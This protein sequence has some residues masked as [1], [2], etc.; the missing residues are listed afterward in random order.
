[1][2][3]VRLCAV[4]SM[5]KAACQMDPSVNT[6]PIAAQIAVRSRRASHMNAPST[7]APQISIVAMERAV[8]EPVAALI[9]APA[10]VPTY[11]MI[12]TTAAGAAMSVP[13]GKFV[14]GEAALATRNVNTCMKPIVA[15]IVLT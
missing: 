9:A 7:F 11:P 4:E 3:L 2:V 6:R 15:A 10:T 13:R 1:M 5:R 8:E 14:S 12:R